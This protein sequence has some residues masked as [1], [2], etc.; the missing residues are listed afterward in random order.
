MDSTEVMHD[1]P[2]FASEE[3]T[4]FPVYAGADADLS[5]LDLSFLGLRF[6]NVN[7]DE[8]RSI[9]EGVSIPDKPESSN[10]I[11]GNNHMRMNYL[12]QKWFIDSIYVL[13]PI[14]LTHKVMGPT[15]EMLRDAFLVMFP[16]DFTLYAS[17]NCNLLDKKHL[18]ITDFVILQEPPFRGEEISI[19]E[20]I[21][22]FF[23]NFKAE[24]VPEIN[25]FLK[26]FFE[27]IESLKYV[28]IALL[29][30]V[31]TYFQNQLH[32]AF[33]SLFMS[34]ETIGSKSHNEITY[35]IRRNCAVINGNT[36]EE[37][38]VIFANV[39][40]L[41]DLRSSIVHGAK[42]DWALVPIRKTGDK[43]G[44]IQGLSVT[45]LIRIRD[46]DQR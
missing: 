25:Q 10:N 34:L 41:Y 42:I 5:S 2:T 3:K 37:S 24:D 8:F 44:K 27:R 29:N 30:Y 18:V 31:S 19:G 45:R 21:F 16:S 12:T 7:S 32:M 36:L 35:R 17:L 20:S 13:L 15:P 6:L 28:Q 1:E 23:V 11:N 4:S 40:T 9:F 22:K 39:G 14:D 33:I 46:Q 43:R 38:R 26:L